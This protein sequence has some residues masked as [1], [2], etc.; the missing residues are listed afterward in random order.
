VTSIRQLSG[1][2]DSLLLSRCSNYGSSCCFDGLSPVG[3]QI[4]DGG[5][6]ANHLEIIR[7]INLCCNI[8]IASTG[9][10]Y[11]IVCLSNASS[12][13]PSLIVHFPPRSSP[14]L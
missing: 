5:K 6:T 1:R 3:Q 10:E 2:G 8:K 14:Q 13:M 7:I 12:D 11:R 4:H 9:V